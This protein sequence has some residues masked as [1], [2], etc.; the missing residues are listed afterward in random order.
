MQADCTVCLL[1]CVTMLI[2]IFS[3]GCPLPPQPHCVACSDACSGGV[4]ALISAWPAALT[5]RP[6]AHRA[7]S[8]SSILF[9]QFLH[10]PAT[11][12]PGSPPSSAPLGPGTTLRSASRWPHGWPGWLGLA[13]LPLPPRALKRPTVQSRS[14]LGGIGRVQACMHAS[15]L[16]IRLS[17]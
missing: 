1:Y 9:L 6:C 8:R 16:C 5:A 7:A 3:D 4:A 11:P 2:R 15:V 14:E 12:P 17:C 13:W 10:S